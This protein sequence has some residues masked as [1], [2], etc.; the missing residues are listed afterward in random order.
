MR[1]AGVGYAGALIS[2]CQIIPPIETLIMVTLNRPGA[3]A[4]MNAASV[5]VRS[6]F[7]ETFAAAATPSLSVSS[8]VSSLPSRYQVIR[9]GAGTTPS[10]DSKR[11][12]RQDSRRASPSVKTSTPASAW[13]RRFS[14]IARSSA[15]RSSAMASSPFSNASRASSR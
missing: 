11:P 3:R 12:A 2:G 13:I 8:G 6:P 15:A 14:S 5:P 10:T 1:S 7:R 9:R 4:A